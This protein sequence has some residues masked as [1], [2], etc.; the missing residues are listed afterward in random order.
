ML[1]SIFSGRHSLL[2]AIIS[3]TIGLMATGCKDSTTTPASTSTYHQVNLVADT[4]GQGATAVDPN[5]LNPWG[6]AINPGNGKV[7]IADNHSGISTV[8]DASGATTSTLVRIPTRDS[9]FGGS[10]TGIVFNSTSDFIVPGSTAAVFIFAT[11]DGTISAWNTS[12]GDAAK[13]VAIKPDTNTVYLGL[14]E[15]GSSLFAANFKGKEVDMYDRSFA[16]VKSFTDPGIPSDYGPFNVQ[17]IAG[18]LYVAYAKHDPATGEELKGA[19]NGFISVF[20]AAGTFVK[21]FASNGKLNAPWGMAIAPSNFG[22]YSGD[23]LVGNFGDGLIHVF[24]PSTGS[25]LGELLAPGDPNPPI[26]I[27]GLWGLAVGPSNTL[28]FAAGIDD[29]NHGLFGTLAP[30]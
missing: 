18:S 5:L 22:S 25:Y 29:V 24:D 6:I 9:A 3:V 16:L 27:E 4:A 19:G 15:I 11:E 2:A 23:L 1:R 13:L 8:Y 12:M 26:Q 14:A 28:Y 21:R 30:H 20:D 7:W 17:N 10:P